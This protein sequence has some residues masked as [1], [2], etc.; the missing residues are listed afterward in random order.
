MEFVVKLPPV[1]HTR[2]RLHVAEHHGG[3][4]HI[5]IF[6]VFGLTRPGTEP[7]STD[8]VADDALST[9]PLSS[10]YFYTRPIHF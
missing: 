6:I 1:Y 5:S 4:L 2:W 3:K 10:N 8:S 9:R 7:G